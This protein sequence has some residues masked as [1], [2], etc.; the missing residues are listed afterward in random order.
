MFGLVLSRGVRVVAL[1][2][3]IGIAAA[4]DSHDT[5]RA[6]LYGVRPIDPLA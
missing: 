5:S 3:V 4:L 6:L 2:V 1:G